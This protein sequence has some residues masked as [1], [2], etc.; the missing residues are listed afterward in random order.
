MTDDAA[1]SQRIPLPPVTPHAIR[2]ARAEAGTAAADTAPLLPPFVAGGSPSA[3]WRL[4]FAPQRPPGP[5][6]HARPAQE[7]PAPPAAAEPT[8]EPQPSETVAQP[9]PEPQPPQTAA[10]PTPEP[11]PP[12]P[13]PWEEPWPWEAPTHEDHEDSGAT[14]TAE[15]ETIADLFVPGP[16]DLVPEPAAPEPQPAEAASWWTP[17]QVEPERVELKPE[18][19]PEPEAWEPW[20]PSRL[21]EA[22]PTPAGPVAAPAP[23]PATAEAQPWEPWEPA[24]LWAE[25]QQEL[26][27]AAAGTDAA[28][29]A[30][31]D[32]AVAPGFGPRAGNGTGDAPAASLAERVAARLESLA[33]DVRASGVAALGATDDADELSR[34]LA[35]VVAGFVARDGHD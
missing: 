31:A 33:R 15:A 4:P 32:A 5:Q 22:A 8:S 30:D 23:E 29:T 1:A 16:F 35:G 11:E 2:T 3:R 9:T 17:E 26:P 18:P 28:W 10:Q 6:H 34:L 13:M 20:E 27:S 12:A 21:W 19:E 14:A 7:L 24:Q 25:P